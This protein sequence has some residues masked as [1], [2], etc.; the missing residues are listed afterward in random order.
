MKR[1]FIVVAVIALLAIS[2]RVFSQNTDQS[3]HP[4]LDKYYPQSHQPANNAP[5]TKRTTPIPPS[6]QTQTPVSNAPVSNNAPTL[7]V[8][9]TNPGPEPATT[10][11]A[12]HSI[13]T[14]S[15]GTTTTTPPATTILTKPAMI[16][17]TSPTQP[18][19]TQSYDPNSLYDTRLGSSSPL[20]N[21]Y[22]KNSNG[23]GTVTISPK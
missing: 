8:N 20:Y 15:T 16:T 2:P 6:T 19:Q 21:T 13:V 10:T 1:K 7:P 14:D 3:S 18:T 12:E 9:T 23:E 11:A 17:K 4:L 5:Q 22:E